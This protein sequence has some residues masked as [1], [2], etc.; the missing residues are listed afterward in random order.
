MHPIS[1]YKD[2]C[3]TLALQFLGCTPSGWGLSAVRAVQRFG[4]LAAVETHTL[5]YLGHHCWLVVGFD[6]LGIWHFWI[7]T[8]FLPFCT[9]FF[10]H[11]HHIHCFSRLISPHHGDPE[12]AGLSFHIKT[13]C[14]VYRLLFILFLHYL[15]PF[16]YYGFNLITSIPIVVLLNVLCLW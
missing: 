9:L 12:K 7:S 3:A 15:S 2:L 16:V 13:I 5:W 14:F 4:R 10:V 1:I 6:A 11:S 8:L